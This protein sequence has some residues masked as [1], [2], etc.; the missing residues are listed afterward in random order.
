VAAGAAVGTLGTAAANSV[1]GRF[2][3]EA[4]EIRDQQRL[5]ATADATADFMTHLAAGSSHVQL[6][7]ASLVQKQR[8]AL[9]RI[10]GTT[11][12]GEAK[13]IQQ[14]HLATITGHLRAGDVEYNLDEAVSAARR[15]ESQ[16]E[17][18]TGSVVMTTMGV[19]VITPGFDAA[20][21]DPKWVDNPF[22]QAFEAAM[23][24]MPSTVNPTEVATR[25]LIDLHSQGRVSVLE[26]GALEFA[27]PSTLAEPATWAAPDV[28]SAPATWAAPDVA[29][30]PS[31]PAFTPEAPSGPAGAGGGSWWDRQAPPS[32]SLDTTA[33][34]SSL[35]EFARAV[36]AAAPTAST[37]PAAATAAAAPAG[38]PRPTPS[39]PAAPPGKTNPRPGSRRGNGG[40]QRGGRGRRGNRGGRT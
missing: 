30:A 2:Q 33:A 4:A 26:G 7:E 37:A 39:G 28:A 17:L 18:P 9:E 10:E 21:I 12:L 23:V 13:R 27:G 35:D 36:D 34:Q 40:R 25:V 5:E 3:G 19:P 11:S 6:D 32:P 29:S 8:E 24:G 22:Q 15:F 1:I 38:S 31:L 14:D 20:S 16:F